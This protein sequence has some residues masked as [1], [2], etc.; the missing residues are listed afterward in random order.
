SD[1][2]EPVSNVMRGLQAVIQIEQS[3]QSAAK[4]I[5][6]Q[7]M[8]HAAVIDS[9]HFRGVVSS[10]A[11]L[12]E[13]QHSWDP[14]TNL[15]WSDRLREWGA[16][17]L[18]EDNEISIIFIDIDDFGKYNKLHG[19]KIGDD[20]IK[21]LA[22]RLE[23]AI[24][25][26][27]DLLVRYA[28]DEFA[29]G[30]LRSRAGAE[31]FIESLEPHHLT[32]AGVPGT[33]GYSCGIS[34]GKRTKNPSRTREEADVHVQATLD[35]LINLASRA[36]IANKNRKKQSWP[37]PS[38]QMKLVEARV[39]VGEN[40]RATVVLTEN[41]RTVSGDAQASPKKKLRAMA[42]AAAHALEALHPDS[43]V[44]ID[45]VVIHRDK[46]GETMV[47]V[48]GHLERGP[49]TLSFRGSHPSGKDEGL[50]VALA[51]CE[52]YASVA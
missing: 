24:D 27:L 6:T 43:H 20:V 22:A 8:D 32:V 28:G 21:T 49:L 13:L 35:N 42:M 46:R 4:A 45:D 44:Q 16:A 17:K 5:L 2:K 15:P 47:S 37:E 40:A 23:G 52:G 1:P 26:D 25:P 31:H 39:E 48:L 19:H 3:V 38:S 18:D 12:G 30:T 33:V 7:K 29:I 41:G 9:G 10:L 51:V 11:L 50:S 36:C 14:M 34:G